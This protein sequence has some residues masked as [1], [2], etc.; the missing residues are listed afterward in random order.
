[1]G[2]FE[3]RF[4]WDSVYYEPGELKVKVWKEGRKWAEDIMRTTESAY[5]VETLVDRESILAN[6]KD[7]AFVTV[8]ILDKEDLLVPRSQNLVKFEIKGPGKIVAVGNGDPTSHESFISNERSAF[9]GKCLV[10]VQSKKIPGVIK[11]VARSKNLTPST[12]EIEVN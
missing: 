3:Y 9:N 11:L 10:V 5:K 8:N 4:R 6:G 12:I 1:M 2:D 7:L